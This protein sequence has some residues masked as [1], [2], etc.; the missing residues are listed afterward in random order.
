MPQLAGGAPYSD[1]SCFVCWLVGRRHVYTHSGYQFL[2]EGGKFTAV[3]CSESQKCY[4]SKVVLGCVQWVKYPR[5]SVG[6]SIWRAGRGGS[7][8]VYTVLLFCNVFHSFG[9]SLSTP[10]ADKMV[11]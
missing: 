4:K 9:V 3:G 10:A 2:A 11:K 8:C 6:G 1:L 5:S 7:T